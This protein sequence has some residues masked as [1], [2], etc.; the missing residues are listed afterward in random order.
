MESANERLRE[1]LIRLRDI[2]Q[3]QEKELRDQIAGLE[4]DIKELGPVKEQHDLTKEKLADL[5]RS[6]NSLRTT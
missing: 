1:A 3:D 5:N 2:T 6:L 4:E